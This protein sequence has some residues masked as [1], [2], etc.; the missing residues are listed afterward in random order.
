MES[1]G[2]LFGKLRLLKKGKVLSERASL[3]QWFSETME[4]PPKIIGIRIAH[5]SL[6]QLYVIQSEYKDIKHRRGNLPA[7]KYLWAITKT[8]KI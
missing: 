5:L 6:D 7:I 1:I 4:R 2:D 8:V 3:V